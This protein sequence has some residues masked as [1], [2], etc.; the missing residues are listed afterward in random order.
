VDTYR[1]RIV[2]AVPDE[3]PYLY[4]YQRILFAARRPG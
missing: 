3:R 4:T 1:R 2:S